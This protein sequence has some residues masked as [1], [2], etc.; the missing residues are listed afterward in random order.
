MKYFKISQFNDKGNNI[1]TIPNIKEDEIKT[2]FGVVKQI[3][4]YED[5]VFLNYYEKPYPMVSRALRDVLR[6]YIPKVLDI[7]VS[8]TSQSLKMVVSY[9][10]LKLEQ[11]KSQIENSQK[12]EI[13]LDI[14]DIKDKKMFTARAGHIGHVIINLEIAELILRNSISDIQLDEITTF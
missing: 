1:I 10:I 12:T 8:L 5:K 13:I 2:S 4:D 11:I 9:W 3:D 6:P 14:Q 7:S